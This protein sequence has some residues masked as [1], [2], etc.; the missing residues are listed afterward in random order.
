MS[1][2]SVTSPP[3]ARRLA[4]ALAALVALLALA[5]PALAFTPPPLNG[6][7]VDTAGALNPEQIARLDHKLADVRLRTGVAIVAFVAGSLEGEPIED[8]AYQCFNAWHLGEKGKDNGVLLLI[9]PHER[10][11]RIETGKGLEGVLT[12][13]QTDDIRTKFVEPALA[14]DRIFDA[15][16]G[17][18]TAIAR[19][20]TGEAGPPPAAGA[21]HG[22]PPAGSQPLSLSRS[23]SRSAGSSW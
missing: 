3:R 2:H 9:A 20:L 6:H 18:T 15:I 5:F 12:D 19:T 7:V 22:R 21:R 23:A 1:V 17:G 10:K 13:L 4:T 8:V 14:K 11:D 16:D